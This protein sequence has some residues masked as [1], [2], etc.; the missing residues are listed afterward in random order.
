ML[1]LNQVFNKRRSYTGTYR[2]NSLQLACRRLRLFFSAGSGGVLAGVVSKA[3]RVATV[4]NFRHETRG[5]VECMA[6][7][8]KPKYLADAA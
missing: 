4:L 2:Q 7:T 6:M 3:V 1:I 5:H 8:G